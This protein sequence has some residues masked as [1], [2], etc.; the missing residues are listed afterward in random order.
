MT[1]VR[2]KVYPEAATY[3]GPAQRGSFDMAGPTGALGFDWLI[4]EVLEWKARATGYHLMEVSI[5]EERT[6]P[7]SSHWLVQAVGHGSPFPII[8]QIVAAILAGLII[9]KLLGWKVED[10]VYP[11]TRPLEVPAKELAKGVS[12]ALVVGVGLAATGLGTALV[13][14]SRRR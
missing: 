9:I 8:F 13:L 14:A 5:Y 12:T 11:V 2:S 10:I 3:R 7:F 4:E 6:G 1:L